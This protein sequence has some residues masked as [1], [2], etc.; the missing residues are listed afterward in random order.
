[1]WEQVDSVGFQPSVALEQQNI[2]LLVN[3]LSAI[4]IRKKIT[5]KNIYMLIA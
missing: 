5:V 2:L 3:A 4:V 1:M